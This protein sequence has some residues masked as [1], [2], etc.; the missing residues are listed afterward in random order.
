MPTT[1]APNRRERKRKQ[2]LEH[3]AR[4]AFGLFESH[5][6]ET[7]TMELIAATADVAK[8][9]LY[10]HFPVKEAMLAHWVHMELAVDLQHLLAEADKRTG[11][12]PKIMVLLNASA[13]WCD[14]HRGYLPH[15]LRFRFLNI[16]TK[17]SRHGEEVAPRDLAGIFEMR[18]REGQQSGE[19]RKDLAAPHLA[20]LLH[21]LYFGALM[22]WLMLPGLVLRKEFR[23][24]IRLFLQG[25]ARRSAA[26]PR[27][28]K[29]S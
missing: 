27:R 1:Q 5:G 11:F 24:A 20:A 21:H 7:V 4:T 3:L 2:M 25:A 13:D 18:I 16:E 12:L 26:H 23:T 29:K 15:Y 8:G 9:T 22:R 17:P 14:R 6:Y 28:G 19:L 10:N